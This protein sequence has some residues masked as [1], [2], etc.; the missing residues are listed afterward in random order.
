MARLLARLALL[1]AVVAPAA[2][3]P[4]LEAPPARPCALEGRGEPPRHWLGCPGDAGSPRPLADDERLVLGRPVDPNTASARVLAHVSGL[5]RALA[6]EIVRDRDANGPFV[7]LQDLER[8]RG[9]G[10]KRL[11]LARPALTI[12][13]SPAH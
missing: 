12:S 11:A 10:P 2:L 3:R 8:V 4:L 5:S 9:I 7:S 6:R 13:R 1:L